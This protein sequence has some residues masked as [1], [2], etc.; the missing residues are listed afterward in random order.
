M[1]L[2]HKNKAGMACLALT[3]IAMLA[4]STAV[5]QVYIIN[6]S[7]DPTLSA[8]ANFA[9]YGPGGDGTSGSNGIVPNAGTGGA[10]DNAWQIVLT[11]AAGGSAGYAYYG[12]QYQNGGIS[13]NTSANLS[14]YT[15]S[16][17]AE[18]NAGSLNLQLQSWTGAGFGGTQ[19]GTLNTAPSS[20][21]YGNDLVLN[22][23]YTHYSLNL[24]NTSIFQ[25]NSGFIPNGGTIQIAFQ[26][27]GPGAGASGYTE[28]L[29]VD[30]LQLVMVPEP[31]SIALCGL[32]LAAGITF[33]RRRNA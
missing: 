24:G 32:G 1:T 33:L 26:L 7:F 29:N 3:T 8:G 30:N 17:D 5:A 14:D 21:G 31:A 16:F 6:E 18:A 15:L 25:G 27:N 9:H 10:G 13:G 11:A 22:P 23:T 28:T 4:G 2:T 19:T 12:A 20:P